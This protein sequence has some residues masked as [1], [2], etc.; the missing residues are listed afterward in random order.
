MSIH[1][2]YL[3][4]PSWWLAVCS[5]LV[6]HQRHQAASV[7]RPSTSLVGLIARWSCQNMNAVPSCFKIDP[8]QFCLSRRGQ[9]NRRGTCTG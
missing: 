2:M 3:A 8:N 9:L 1:A 5:C 6:P 4:G 7:H